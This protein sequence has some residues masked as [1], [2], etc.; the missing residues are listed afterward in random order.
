MPLSNAVIRALRAELNEWKA[1]QRQ[2]EEK[3]AAIEAI[4]TPSKLT[5]QI[6]EPAPLLRLDTS[7]NNSGREKSDFT[8]LRDRI[9]G[10]LAAHPNVRPR[11]VI[12][13]L[14]KAGVMARGK[15]TLEIKVYNELHRMA[16]NGLLRKSNSGNYSLPKEHDRTKLLDAGEVK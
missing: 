4:L 1:V 2:A 3:T 14:A 10:I 11:V 5:G 13:A 9:R 15:T 8:G 6:K 7:S 16:K 12:D